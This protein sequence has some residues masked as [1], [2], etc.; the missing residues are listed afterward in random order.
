MDVFVT[1]KLVNIT[2]GTILGYLVSAGGLY[3]VAITSDFGKAHGVQDMDIAD[4]LD[5]PVIEV[6]PAGKSEYAVISANIA[7]LDYLADTPVDRLNGNRVCYGYVFQ[8]QNI[9]P[10]DSQAAFDRMI[11]EAQGTLVE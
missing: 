3:K 4:Y 7:Y 6:V 5:V 10:L 8:E 1:E 2:D 11:A 9:V